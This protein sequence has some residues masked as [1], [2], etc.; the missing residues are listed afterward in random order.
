M[1]YLKNTWP[2]RFKVRVQLKDSTTGAS[3]TVLIQG[4]NDDSSYTTIKS[5]SIAIA[6]ADPNQH[7]LTGLVKAEYKFFRANVT[8]L[9]G[10]SAPAVNAYMTLGSFGQ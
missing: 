4:S 9:S 8:A 10:G 5:F 7:T 3:A 6:T 1:R 2:T